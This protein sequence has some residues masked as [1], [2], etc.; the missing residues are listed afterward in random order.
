MNN[1]I[2]IYGLID[3]RNLECFYIGQTRI[4]LKERL[5]QHIRG[6]NENRYKENK[7]NW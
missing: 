7:I 5:A 2:Y 3:P 1:T 4:G 6:K